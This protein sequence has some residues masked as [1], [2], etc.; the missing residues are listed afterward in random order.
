DGAS[1]ADPVWALASSRWCRE[2]G[3]ADAP[4]DVEAVRGLIA[5]G[6]TLSALVRF[7]A[8]AAALQHLRGIAPSRVG[9]AES[10]EAGAP[11]PSRAG[12]GESSRTGA[13]ESLSARISGPGA[14]GSLPVRISE[15][16]AS[17]LSQEGAAPPAGRPVLHA[18]LA[19]LDQPK[20]GAADAVATLRARG[21]RVV[22]ISGDQLAPAQALA[23][24]VG[25]EAADVRAE[26]LPADKA[27]EV[28]ALQAGGHVVAM[29]GDGAN[30]A[31]ALAA[32]DVGIAMADGTD[33]A[34]EAAG[35]TLMRGD[36]AL[37]GEALELSARTVAK[38]RQNLF[39]AFAYNVAGI[40]LAAF[41]LLSPVVAGAAM[42]L[43]SL[44][45]MA[46]ALLLRRRRPAAPGGASV[47]AV[48][49]AAQ[50]SVG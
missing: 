41:G 43:S 17:E 1:A 22:M 6:A 32:A 47:A 27:A 8:D 5:Q 31:P 13:A 37:V 26:V 34:M 35:I 18:W 39:W 11:E 2:L 20:P 3:L 50:S 15:P 19:F 4:E 36:L 24:R 14:T 10:S 33:V 45:V 28:T 23:R 9:A 16:D 40:P 21:L 38:I 49:P 29:V 42:A 48:R 46:N 25:I 30:D 7:E 44:S 12:A